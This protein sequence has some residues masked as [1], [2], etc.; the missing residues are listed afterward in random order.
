MPRR[1]LGRALQRRCSA[2]CAEVQ[3]VRGSAE[4][5]ERCLYSC[6]LFYTRLYTGGVRLTCVG[7]W[8]IG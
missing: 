2:A 3:D 5:P 6:K 4:D 7:K 8:G 1:V